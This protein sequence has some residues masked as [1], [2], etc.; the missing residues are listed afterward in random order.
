MGRRDFY[1]Q[2]C[3]CMD[4]ALG[5]VI[6]T[7]RKSRHESSATSTKMLAM[8]LRLPGTPLVL[9]ERMLP[10]PGPHDLR[11]RVLACGVCRTDLHVVDG[12]LRHAALPIVPGHE[13]VGR[14]E[15][16]G[17]AGPGRSTGPKGRGSMAW[18]DLRLLLLLCKRTR[19][20]V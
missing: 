4:F 17:A 9:E 19:K 14:V 6:N 10:A 7:P 15:V 20:S 1:L 2:V 13:I 12:E 8:I 16:I 3:F 11:L 5:K 18:Q